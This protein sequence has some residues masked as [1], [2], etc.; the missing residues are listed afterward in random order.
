MYTEHDRSLDTGEHYVRV[1]SLMLIT[2][3]CKFELGTGFNTFDNVTLYLRRT[4][5]YELAARTYSYPLHTMPNPS[6]SSMARVSL[7]LND[8]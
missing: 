7:C 2:R 8:S 4:R 5:Y 1:S 3:N 6:H